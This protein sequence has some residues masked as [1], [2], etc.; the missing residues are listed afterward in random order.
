M[1]VARCE[2]C[3]RAVDMDWHV[4]DI[5]FL[6]HPTRAWEETVCDWCLTDAEREELEE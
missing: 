6:P 1:A 2:R 3:S 5:H 4:E